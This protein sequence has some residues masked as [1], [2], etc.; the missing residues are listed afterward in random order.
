MNQKERKPIE[1]YICFALLLA[2]TLVMFVGVIFRYVFNAS[3]S[4]SEELSR[5]LFIWFI[6]LSMSYAVTQKAHIRVESLNRII[7]KKIRPYIN[8]IG[9]IIWLGFGV[10]V[11][12]L[13]IKYAL[14][15]NTSVSAAMKIPMSI[16][17]LG[18]PLGYFLMS[19]RL[20]FQIVESIKN[21]EIEIEDIHEEFVVAKEE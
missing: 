7:P 14:T 16:V 5:Y 1:G 2:M 4:W 12:Y 3:L 18:I 10:F 15:M 11:T 19:L 13:G 21:P 8:I 6:F 17:Y 20:L 9:K